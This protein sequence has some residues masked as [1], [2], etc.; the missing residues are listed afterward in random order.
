VGKRTMKVRGPE[1]FRPRIRGRKVRVLIMK[2]EARERQRL[3]EAMK[4]HRDRN[5]APSEP[6]G[7]L[8]SVMAGNSR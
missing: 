7:G 4:H 2:I 1:G 5:R 8:P 3:K 6:A